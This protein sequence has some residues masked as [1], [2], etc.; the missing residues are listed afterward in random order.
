MAPK[1]LPAEDRRHPERVHAVPLRHAPAGCSWERRLAIFC[2]G[3]RVLAPQLIRPY[4]WLKTMPS[5]R[6]IDTFLTNRQNTVFCGGDDPS[7]WHLGDPRRPLGGLLC[8]GHVAASRERMAGA[9]RATGTDP[10]RRPKPGAYET[11][12]TARGHCRAGLHRPSAGGFARAGFDTINTGGAT[13]L[14]KTVD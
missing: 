2:G 3:P 5:V 13:P 1:R 9:C 12:A 14:R 11:R 7:L 8:W 6:A 10:G 4:S